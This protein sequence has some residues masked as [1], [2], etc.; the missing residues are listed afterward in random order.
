MTMIHREP[1][2]RL[3]LTAALTQTSATVESREVYL[4]ADAVVFPDSLE[5]VMNVFRATVIL[6]PV[7]AKAVPA[8]RSAPMG[9][10]AFVGTELAERL[11]SVAHRAAF[12][13]SDYFPG[14]L[15]V[16]RLSP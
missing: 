12:H 9:L 11:H 7:V 6:P 1:F 3:G 2:P 10:V 4:A 16:N 15:F 14:C 13:M 5:V 8:R